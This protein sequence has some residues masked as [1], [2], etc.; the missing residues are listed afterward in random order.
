LIAALRRPC[1]ERRQAAVVGRGRP[2]FEVE[3]YGGSMSGLIDEWRVL[4]RAWLVWVMP[5]SVAGFA[6]LLGPLNGGFYETFVGSDAQ[7]FDQQMEAYRV[8]GA[9]L[10]TSGFFAGQIVAMLFGALLVLRDS[11]PAAPVRPAKLAAAVLGGAVLG[12]I[13]VVAAAWVAAG[14]VDDRWF[15]LL[16]GSGEVFESGPLRYAGTWRAIVVGLVGFPVWALIGVGLAARF[17]WRVPVA[18]AVLLGPVVVIGATTWVNSDSASPLVLMMGLLL[19]LVCLCV[20][21]ATSNYAAV[22][23][24]ALPGAVGWIVTVV[25][26]LFMLGYATL[27]LGVAHSHWERRV[28]ASPGPPRPSRAAATAVVLASVAVLLA[29]VVTFFG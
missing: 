14:R 8:G 15:G 16:G 21:P 1:S 6:V 22:I 19:S 27:A 20:L 17:R 7:G 12:L 26:V 11:S 28:T 23:Y 29:I 4:R 13:A 3:S 18:A 5:L 24:I 2:A 25:V 10:Y 9:Q